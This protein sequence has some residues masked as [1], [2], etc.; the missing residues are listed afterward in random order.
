MEKTEYK[1]YISDLVEQF[2]K[3][4][5]DD[6]IELPSQ[7]EQYLYFIVET[8]EN[9]KSKFIRKDKDSI[10]AT[11]N[12]TAKQLIDMDLTNKK[13]QLLKDGNFEKIQDFS[14]QAFNNATNIL[15]GE[16]ADTNLD[17]QR[18]IEELEQLLNSVEPYNEKKAKE[19]VSEAILDLQFIANPKT[20]VVSIRLSHLI[21]WSKSGEG[22]KISITKNKEEEEQR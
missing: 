14:N 20:D 22:E 11:L 4:I 19:L 10:I 12:R 16:T 6:E 5:P 3:T 8:L 9:S 2:K 1:T 15:N 21:D 13:K 7:F 17:I 18:R